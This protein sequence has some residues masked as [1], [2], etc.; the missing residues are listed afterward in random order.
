MRELELEG[1]VR[2]GAEG[3]GVKRIQEWLCLHGL[4]VAVDGDFGPATQWSV[5]E[6]QARHRLTRTGVVDPACFDRLV[7]PLRAALAPIEP[8]GRSL[9]EMV[10]AYALQHLAQRPREVGGQNLG[11]WVRLYMDG[12]EGA[13]WAWCVGFATLCLQQ[14]AVS[15][16]RPMPFERTYSCDLLAANA[17]LRQRFLRQP[18]SA[19]GRARVTPGSLFL[20]R[21]TVLDWNHAGIVVAAEDEVVRTVEGN[22]NDDGSA[23]GYEVCARTRGYRS[24]DFV[25]VDVLEPA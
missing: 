12:N 14:A 7:A 15:L 13:P 2:R 6:F 22:T 3:W 1:E 8:A 23:E 16:R 11:P 17:Q 10:V 19:A 5:R 21:R 18:N 4:H 25:L 9:G 20:R 24:M